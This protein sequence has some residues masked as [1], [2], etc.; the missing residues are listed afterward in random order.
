MAEKK[1]KVVRLVKGT[2]GSYERPVIYFLKENSNDPTQH[3][4]EMASSDVFK[5]NVAEV[6]IFE[7]IQIYQELGY[8]V[9]FEGFVDL[10]ECPQCKEEKVRETTFASKPYKTCLNC[11]YDKL[12]EE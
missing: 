12:K 4:Y 9:K 7:R 2:Y 8:D 6:K 10:K 11:D 3:F 5:G 1:D